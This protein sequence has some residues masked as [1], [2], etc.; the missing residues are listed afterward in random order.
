MVGATHDTMNPKEMRQ[1]S[2]LVKHGRYLHCPNGSH[3]A[4]WDDQEVFME[5]VIQ[6]IT[7]VHGAHFP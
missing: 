4:M 6:F 3:L 5:G 1:M 2:D 7:D